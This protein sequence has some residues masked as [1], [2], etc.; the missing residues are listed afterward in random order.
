[1]L[2]NRSKTRQAAEALVSEIDKAIRAMNAEYV[3][4]RDSANR[5]GDFDH[6]IPLLGSRRIHFLREGWSVK[7]SGISTKVYAEPAVLK[8][9]ETILKAKRWTGLMPG[10]N[11]SYLHFYVREPA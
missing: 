3:K 9:V 11:Y 2:F 1:M 10:P 4:Q 7:R 8:I 5:P 6:T